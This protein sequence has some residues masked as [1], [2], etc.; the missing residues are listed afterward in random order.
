MSLSHSKLWETAVKEWDII[1][2]EEDFSC[3]ESCVCGKE[4]L[5]YLYT[6]KNRETSEEL[7]PIGSSCIK[8]FKNKELSE[9]TTDLEK[10]FNLHHAVEDGKYIKLT[11]DFFSKRL[12]FK[13]YKEGAFDNKYN[14]FDGTDDYEFM[15][16]MFNKKDKSSITHNQQR[17]IN[18]IIINSIKPYLA[19]KLRTKIKY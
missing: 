12:L 5:H 8:K 13:L 19:N 11:S 16:K 9:K 7:Y 17:K 15:L 4:H 6:I 1:D 3:S 2:C 10:M 18:A 14:K